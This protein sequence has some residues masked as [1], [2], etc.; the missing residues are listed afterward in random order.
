[1]EIWSPVGFKPRTWTTTS[2]DSTLLKIR[3]ALGTYCCKGIRNEIMDWLIL[4]MS[5]PS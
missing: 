4:K 3:N 2:T 1:M 5:L